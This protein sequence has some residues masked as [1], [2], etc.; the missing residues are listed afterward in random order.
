MPAINASTKVSTS[1]DFVPSMNFF[2]AFRNLAIFLAASKLIPCLDL[3][4][5]PASAKFSITSY[6]LRV[7]TTFSKSLLG[8]C[9]F[10]RGTM[11]K[12]PLTLTGVTFSIS[13]VTLP[14][15]TR[16]ADLF[17]I[18]S[19]FIIVLTKTLFIPIPIFFISL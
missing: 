9:I 6:G 13:F 11:T 16:L 7:C 10:L 14:S 15:F 1:L 12:L 17:Q 3:S 2:I 8:S 19:T 18:C 5:V 4:T